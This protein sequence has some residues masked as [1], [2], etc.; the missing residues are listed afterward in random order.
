MIG[1]RGGEWRVVDRDS[2]GDAKAR[3]FRRKPEDGGR[4]GK[5]D[6]DKFRGAPWEP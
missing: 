6:F 3:D 1:Y 5:E 4:W 2:E